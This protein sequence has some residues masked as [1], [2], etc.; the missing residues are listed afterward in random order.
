MTVHIHKSPSCKSSHI[1]IAILFILHDHDLKDHTRFTSMQLIN[2]RYNK[3]H[4]CRYGSEVMQMHCL[5]DFILKILIF[6]VQN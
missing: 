5:K 2:V 1:L 6:L 4:V 3:Y